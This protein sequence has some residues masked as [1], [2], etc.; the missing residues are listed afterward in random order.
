MQ[1]QKSK[2]RICFTV[3][4]ALGEIYCDYGI[5][6]D[7]HTLEMITITVARGKSQLIL[8]LTISE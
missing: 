6:M 4:Y 8:A 3:V 2:R 7:K 5:F 1:I